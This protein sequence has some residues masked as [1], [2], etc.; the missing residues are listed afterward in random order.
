MFIYC[1]YKYFVVRL[2]QYR[3][4]VK[5]GQMLFRTLLKKVIVSKNVKKN[6]CSFVRCCIDLCYV[7]QAPFLRC[8]RYTDWLTSISNL[9]K[10]F[11]ADF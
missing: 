3:C 7:T 8:S 10:E 2:Q 11:S 1:R 6:S 9:H 4:Y 5:E